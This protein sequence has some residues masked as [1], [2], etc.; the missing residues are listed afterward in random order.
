MATS[1][2]LVEWDGAMVKVLS[3]NFLEH[4]HV[5]WGLEVSVHGVL[6]VWQSGLANFYLIDLDEICV[7]N[8]N[9]QLHALT[10]TI[11]Q[12]KVS[13]MADRVKEINPELVVHT[14]Q[15]FFTEKTEE[16]LLGP[17]NQAMPRFDVL[18]DAIDQTQRKVNL[19]IACLERE[20]PVVTCQG[21]RWSTYSYGYEG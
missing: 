14:E 11:G 16:E 4:T 17:R 10:S 9:R 19:I 18:I 8:I 5:L 21:S 7:T 20:I 15:R 12:A 2:A 3:I 1:I 6:R 13:A